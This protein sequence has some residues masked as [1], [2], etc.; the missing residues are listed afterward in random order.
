MAWQYLADHGE[1]K[2]LFDQLSIEIVGLIGISLRDR[3][4]ESLGTTNLS[5]EDK[6]HP[7]SDKRK[8]YCR[9]WR[10]RY[11]EGYLLSAKSIS[12]SCEVALEDVVDHIRNYFAIDISNDFTEQNE[13]EA[14]L[15][16]RAKTIISEGENSIQSIYSVDKY[17]IAKAMTADEIPNDVKLLIEEIILKFA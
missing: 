10:R 6:S 8:I 12:R 16:A 3:D 7:E 13:P 17:K 2:K 5:L 14:I 9:K 11:I 1:R 15:D 4:D